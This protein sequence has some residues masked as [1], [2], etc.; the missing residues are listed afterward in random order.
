MFQKV[1]WPCTVQINCCRDFKILANSLPS[2]SNFKGFSQSLEHFFLTVGQNNFGN[3]IPFLCYSA[4]FTKSFF[5]QL[6]V[7]C[8]FNVKPEI[9]LGSSSDGKRILHTMK[10]NSYFR[11]F[12]FSI[13]S[14]FTRYLHYIVI[15]YNGNW[16]KCSCKTLVTCSS[17]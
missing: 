2:A 1:Y 13:S 11:T 4:I 14:V 8:N 6:R 3:K 12:L 15:T 16:R 5:H 9:R 7:H 10:W 17:D